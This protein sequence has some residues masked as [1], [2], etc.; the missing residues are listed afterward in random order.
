MNGERV[1]CA[2]ERSEP[3]S[4]YT[5][6]LVN[7]YALVC[8][9]LLWLSSL[10]FVFVVVVCVCVVVVGGVACLFVLLFFVR[11]VVCL[12]CV[13]VCVCPRKCRSGAER[14]ITETSDTTEHQIE[15]TV[16]AFM[17]S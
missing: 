10:L 12:L 2:S 16:A 7:P 8:W 3:N 5:R 15:G 14:S 17:P 1:E 4:E 6:R 13:C 9:F 11:C